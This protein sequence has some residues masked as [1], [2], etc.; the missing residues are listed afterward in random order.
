MVLD[1]PLTGRRRRRR[2]GDLRAIRAG[3]VYSVID[4]IARNGVL[5]FHAETAAG[6]SIPM[7]GEL[8]SGTTATLVARA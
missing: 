5:D 6:Q 3:H 2:E 1:R 4:G 8:P 7:G